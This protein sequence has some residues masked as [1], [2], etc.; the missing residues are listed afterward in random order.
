MFYTNFNMNRY[1]FSIILFVLMVNISCKSSKKVFDPATHD[2]AYLTF[3]SGGGFSGKVIKYYLT[4]DGYL[5]MQDGDQNVM[6][7]KAP[8][9]MTEQ[10]MGNYD[11]LGFDKMDLNEPGNK[12]L[13]IERKKDGQTT[14]IK[15][16]KLPLKNKNVNTYFDVLMSVVKKLKP[17]QDNT[18]K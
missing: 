16:G 17:Q 7:G 14:M 10:V 3:G 15:W 11:K 5:Y 4:E 2:K 12:Y 6:V 9:T 13:F 8:K 18:T 1:F